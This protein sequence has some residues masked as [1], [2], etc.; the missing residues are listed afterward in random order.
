MDNLK[1]IDFKE[2]EKIMKKEI[3]DIGYESILIRMAWSLTKIMNDNKI[4]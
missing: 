1:K 3:K 2:Y 4:K